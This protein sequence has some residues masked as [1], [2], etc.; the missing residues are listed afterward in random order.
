MTTPVLQPMPVPARRPIRVYIAGAHSTGK[1][2]LARWVS[3]TY[4]LPL[5]TE[6]ARAVLAENEITLEALRTD[7]ERT[8]DFQAE[9]FKRQAEAEE[10]AGPRFVSD[11]AFDNLA[12]AASHT[13]ALSR[14]M[15]TGVKKYADRLK[16]SGSI[17]F[18]VRPHRELLVCDGTRERLDWEEI[19]RID[20]MI[21]MLFELHDID[22]VSMMD[23]SMAM[24]ARTIKAVMGAAGE[25][26]R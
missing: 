10:R 5:V 22:F 16:R 11:R 9:V 20:G 17:V 8:A 14:I 12:Y 23:L 21:R 24:R 26:Q 3:K 7:I 2:T 1:T 13:V 25:R 15:A 19:V 18:F 4:G 6:V